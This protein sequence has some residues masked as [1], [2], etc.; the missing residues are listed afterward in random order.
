MFITNQY[1]IQ[2]NL[3]DAPATNDTNPATGIAAGGPYNG[4]ITAISAAGI[5]TAIVTGAGVMPLITTQATVMPANTTCNYYSIDLTGVVVVA[6]QPH[7]MCLT[8]Y[9]LHISPYEFVLDYKLTCLET[10]ATNDIIQIIPT[11]ICNYDRSNQS[12]YITIPNAAIANY[13][14]ANNLI[15]NVVFSRRN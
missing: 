12:F 4:A 10:T 13:T 1:S 8:H 7:T 9:N 15:L 3:A 14:N 2:A 11:L 6:G 5:P